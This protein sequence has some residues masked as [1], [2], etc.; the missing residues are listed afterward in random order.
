MSSVR[1]SV[2][3][4]VIALVCTA[5]ASPLSAAPAFPAPKGISTLAAPSDVTDFSSRR[6]YRHY[7]RGGSAAGL[8]FMGLAIGTITGVIAAQQRRDDCYYYGYCGSGYY[9]VPYYYG[10][11]YYYYPPY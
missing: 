1:Q 5:F 7:R 10:R 6:R 11:R 8:A 3:A 9:G 2:L 4:M